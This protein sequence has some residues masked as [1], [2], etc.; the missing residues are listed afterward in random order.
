[1]SRYKFLQDYDNQTH[2]VRA[3]WVLDIADG[4][5]APLIASGTLEKMSDTCPLKKGN[6]D[7]Y[8]NCRP[9]SES[10]IAARAARKPKE[11]VE[12]TVITVGGPTIVTGSTGD[13][14]ITPV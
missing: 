14:S 5:A 8:A 12:T 2:I 9:L 7:N 4:D 13:W 10:V 6:L 11:P 1:M 3:G